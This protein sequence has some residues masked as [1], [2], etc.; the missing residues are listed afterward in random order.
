MCLR[1][2]FDSAPDGVKI[3]HVLLDAEATPSDYDVVLLGNLR[4]AGGLGEESEYRWA[5]T[6]GRKLM[7]Y[8]G[9]VIKLEF[10]I[11]PCT[12]RDG[13]C[14]NYDSPEQI[15]CTCSRLIP[16][17]FEN[18]YNLCDAVI[19]ISPLQQRA[20]HNIIDIR[21][22]VEYLMGAPIDFELF[23][24]EIPFAERKRA[25][26]ITGD[27]N[28]IAPEAVELAA[29]RGYAVEQ[30]DYL[31]VPYEEMPALLNQYQAVVIAPVMLHAFARLAT[32][33]M[34]CGCEVITNNRVGAMSWADPLTASREA[35]DRFWK[36]LSQ[37]PDRPNPLRFIPE[38]IISHQ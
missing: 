11:N 36:I 17:S 29:E 20:I 10:D 2:H 32:E 9:Y 18:L 1:H 8:S 22:P 6:W 24:D 38:S 30:V 25:A 31:S 26:L 12:F 13:R 5:R 19:F 14:Y 33:A 34:A 16:D 4:P 7:N 23:R 28:R 21:A 27:E 15:P 37:K 35:N 3:D